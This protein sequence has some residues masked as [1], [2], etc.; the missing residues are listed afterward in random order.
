[1]TDREIAQM[2]IVF[3]ERAQFQGRELQQLLEVNRMIGSI[4]MGQANVVPIAVAQPAGEDRR[5]KGQTGEKSDVS[6]ADYVAA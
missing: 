1:M 2:A 4:A 5:S 6:E 3:L